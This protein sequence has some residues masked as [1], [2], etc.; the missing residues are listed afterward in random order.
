MTLETQ[1]GGSGD[2]PCAF[3]LVDTSSDTEAVATLGPEEGRWV[4]LP[5]GELCWCC[6]ME[7]AAVGSGDQFAEPQL[8]IAEIAHNA[9]FDTLNLR[10]VHLDDSMMLLFSGP[11]DSRSNANLAD[12]GRSNGSTVEA[13]QNDVRLVAEPLSSRKRRVSEDALHTE[14]R[15]QVMRFR[16]CAAYSVIKKYYRK[17]SRRGDREWCRPGCVV[18][19]YRRGIGPLMAGRV[20]EGYKIVSK[21]PALLEAP[22]ANVPMEH[23]LRTVMV[24]VRDIVRLHLS[25]RSNFVMLQIGEVCIRLHDD[26]EYKKLA[27]MKHQAYAYV[28][29]FTEI[30]VTQNRHRAGIIAQIALDQDYAPSDLLFI[31][32]QTGKEERV[33]KGFPYFHDTEGVRAMVLPDCV[34]AVPTYRFAFGISYFLCFFWALF[35]IYCFTV[36]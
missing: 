27:A 23:Q 35:L 26:N 1:A 33:R 31:D 4:T 2:D 30:R 21:F 12:Q 9:P 17:K 20:P 34:T 7:P 32:E 15:R 8:I 16:D 14:E 36:M 24:R 28:H 3:L 5:N 6:D 13:P 22:Q 10:D 19:M 11:D 18:A 29:N 25:Q